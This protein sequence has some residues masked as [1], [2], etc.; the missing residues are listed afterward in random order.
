[1]LKVDRV[2]TPVRFSL[3]VPCS[4][5]SRTVSRYCLNAGFRGRVDCG[6]TPRLCREGCAGSFQ[7]PVQGVAGPPL[8][9]LR[10]H[11]EL[12]AD[13]LG[14]HFAHARAHFALDV[15]RKLVEELAGY[16]GARAGEVSKLEPVDVE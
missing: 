14:G 11:L 2:S 9:F 8:E 5:T 10:A 1:M 13:R 16:L 7:Q 15:G 12:C 3:R 4:S 6:R